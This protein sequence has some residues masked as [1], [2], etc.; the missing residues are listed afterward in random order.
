MSVSLSD[1][2]RVRPQKVAVLGG[3]L[4]SCTAALALTDQPGW[5]ERYD[6]TIYQLGW[7]LG[8][9]ARSG[10]NKDYGQRSEG[11][12]S[13]LLVGSHFMLKTLMKSVYEELNRP[14]GV[15]LRTFE[16]AFK[17]KS[18][19]TER[20]PDCEVDIKCFSADYL[21]EKL[22]GSFLWMTEKMIQELQINYTINKEHFNSNSIF[23]KSQAASVQAL[24]KSTFL[25]LKRNSM[26]Q[27]FL[28]VIDT[29]ATVIIGFIEEDLIER[30]FYTIN[31]LDLC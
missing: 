7:R 16:E 30:G 22:T 26:K 10:R 15:P 2:K 21:F 23:L 20:E 13:H 19:F 24:V 5:K 4:S 8:G 14:E 31:D 17:P 3:G 1:G 18:L 27:E 11:I 25:T 12:T 28:S 9:K 29:T 6:I